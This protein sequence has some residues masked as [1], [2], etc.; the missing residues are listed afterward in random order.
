MTN[1]GAGRAIVAA[2]GEYCI[3][4]DVCGQTYDTIAGAGADGARRRIHHGCDFLS[5][6]LRRVVIG[7]EQGRRLQ[8]VS[9]YPRP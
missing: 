9:F 4:F 3:E 2:R 7:F 1:G 8:R 5:F 6:S